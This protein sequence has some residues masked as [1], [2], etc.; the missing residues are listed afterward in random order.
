MKESSITIKPMILTRL[1]P[2]TFIYL[3]NFFRYLIYYPDCWVSPRSFLN[4]TTLGKKVSVS[5]GVYLN[6]C[7]IGDYTYIS[8]NDAGGIVTGIHHTTIGKFCSLGNHIEIITESAH[9]YQKIS[10]YPFL[11]MNNSPLF[12]SK[13]SNPSIIIKPVTIGNDV[14]IGSNVIILG[15]ISIGDGAVIGAGSVVT[16]NVKPYTIVV[17][18]PARTLKKRFTNSQIQKIQKTK[19]WNWSLKKIKKNIKKLTDKP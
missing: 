3:Y 16:K 11:T 12:Q 2:N 8:G 17:G 18:N 19:W 7:L 10:Q 13:N 4:Q 9:D 6:D 1:I 14:W 15:G 5:G